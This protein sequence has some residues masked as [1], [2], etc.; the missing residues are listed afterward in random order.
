[1]E[2]GSRQRDAEPANSGLDQSKFNERFASN[3]WEP[4][5]RRENLAPLDIRPQQFQRQWEPAIQHEQF[6]QPQQ[7]V[8]PPNETPSVRP[9]RSTAG[10]SLPSL[11][12]SSD[13]PVGRYNAENKAV[14]VVDKATHRTRVLQMN[15]ERVEEVL[16]VP[17]A[18]GKGPK[19]TPEGRFNIIS[20]ETN[21]W[22]YPP[23]HRKEKPV[24]PGPD[25][26]LGPAKIKP[27]V[28]VG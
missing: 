14:V 23:A 8:T 15:N 1:M 18:T 21:P 10:D 9:D 16:N 24:A 5:I 7:R 28:S 6:R 26:P 19:M 17:D 13:L 3:S 25:N 27:M 12:I 20:K 11:T 2:F 22:W 4:T